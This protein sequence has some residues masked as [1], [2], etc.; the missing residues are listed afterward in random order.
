[1]MKTSF[2]HK[3]FGLA[4]IMVGLAACD[5]AKQDVSP[6]ISPDI[7]PL[8]TFTTDFTGTISEGDTI[9]YTITLDKMIE[10]AITFSVKQTGGTAD[11]NDWTAASAVMEPY[12]KEVQLNLI[13]TADN[14]PEVAETATFE[15]GAF[16]IAD[17]YLV[18]P[19]TVNPKPSV[20]IT[21]VNNTE[22]NNY[23]VAVG[24]PNTDDDW[25]VRIYSATDGRWSDMG[26]SGAD[27]EIIDQLWDGD[28]D[29]TYYIAVNPYTV[30]ENVTNFTVSIGHSD[31]TVSFYTCQFNVA[32]VAGYTTSAANWYQI[33]K[34]EKVGSVYTLT[35]L[36]PVPTK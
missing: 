3:I 15:I 9:K 16:T 2:K 26:E 7:K 22:D 12:T 19:A 13:I 25:D 36:M 11:A 35:N 30:T 4:L 34:I 10:R 21:N 29:G 5:T 1:M 33:M 27:P 24:W 20:N 8:A 17:R 18:R 28:P 32:D 14:F 31:Q 23:T 6:I